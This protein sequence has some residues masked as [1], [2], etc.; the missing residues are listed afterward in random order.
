VPIFSI[1]QGICLTAEGKRGNNHCSQLVLR[2]AARRLWFMIHR[3]ARLY[4]MALCF[5]LDC[6]LVLV[7][8]L[9]TYV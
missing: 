3:E 5:I 2:L 1:Y 8:I 4:T 7:S 6:T 9:R